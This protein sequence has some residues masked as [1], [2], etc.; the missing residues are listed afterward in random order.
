MLLCT[1]FPGRAAF[2]EPDY[3]LVEEL[4]SAE[5]PSKLDSLG[6]SL[7]TVCTFPKAALETKNRDITNKSAARGR[8]EEVLNAVKKKKKE[9]V[10]EEAVMQNKSAAVKENCAFIL[11]NHEARKE[12]RGNEIEG[13]KKAVAVLA[14][15]DYGAEAVAQAAP[16]TFLQKG[17]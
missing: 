2:P 3:Y 12:A 4:Y 7:A 15:A 16:T 10:E 6:Q 9:S 14:G 8:L 1:V 17:M 11:E 13:L 5:S